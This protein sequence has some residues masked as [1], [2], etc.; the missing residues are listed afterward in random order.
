VA[1]IRHEPRAHRLAKRRRRGCRAALFFATT[2]TVGLG[3]AGPALAT[4][5]PPPPPVPEGTWAVPEPEPALL[6]TPAIPVPELDLEPVVVT[7]VD[8]GNVDVS[9][10]VLSPGE[11]G[12][13]TQESATAV[14]S[15][16]TQPDITATSESTDLAPVETAPVESVAPTE[17][18]NT[19]VSIRVLSPG[20]RGDVAQSTPGSGE[21]VVEAGTGPALP[22][23]D[24]APASAA[25]TSGASDSA[26]YQ[27][28]NS[29]YQ[30]ENSTDA[31][32]WH[33]VWLL[34][35]DCSG[36]AS[37]ISTETGYRESLVWSWEWQWEWACSGAEANEQSAESGARASPPAAS[38]SPP[39]EQGTSSPGPEP[40]VAEPWVWT[41]TF[42]F[43]GET[44]TISTHAGTGT[45]L[46]WTWDWTWTWTCPTTAAPDAQPLPEA[47]AT[48]P[49]GAATGGG[50]EDAA[51]DAGRTLQIADGAPAVT[52]PAVW[53]PTVLPTLQ[54][55][56]AVEVVVVPSVPMVEIAIPPV[57]LPA[58]TAPSRPLPAIPF[59]A[60]DDAAE[61]TTTSPG[62]PPAR[63]TITPGARPIAA[64]G[65]P[66]AQVDTQLPQSQ[67]RVHQARPAKHARAQEERSKRDRRQLPLERRQPRQALGSSSSAGGVV[68]SALLLGFA[69]LTGF[70]A[71]A[72]PGVGRR[73]RVAQELRPRSPDRSP[74]DHP[75]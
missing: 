75:G 12:T 54:P 24:P 70:I 59:P 52:L 64:T 57:V 39:A 36:Y 20:D 27:P 13:V 66:P 45:P 37:S 38:E 30:P 2:A 58:S 34:S 49:L 41:W 56:A 65:Y 1:D 32:P 8:A 42:T 26:Q 21:E 63:R 25:P 29:R 48:P 46:T 60:V 22:H 11:D 18:T 51:V 67:P 72:A 73:I 69:V 16:A 23:A 17:A 44:R 61:P 40:V 68:S 9:V 43:C 55:G 33:W 15:P 47:G 74:I 71:L 6:P 19:N 3:V 28:E 5:L 14:V 4:E 50:V 62:L 53:L 10:R 7:Q 31:D 35:L